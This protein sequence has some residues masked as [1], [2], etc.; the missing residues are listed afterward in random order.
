[1]TH[2]HVFDMDGTL[3]RG[4]ASVE[5][6]RHLG[7]FE[8]ASA[9]EDGW[10][11]GEI[12]ERGFWERM[13]P[14]WDGVSES[15]V[16]DAFAGASW[17]A[18]VREVLADVAAR[19]E[20]AIVISQSPHFFV[21]RLEGWGAHRAYGSRVGPDVPAGT[22]RTLTGR[23]KVEITREVLDGLGLTSDA[24]VAYGDSGSDTELFALLAHTVAVNATAALRERASA[25]YDGDDLR[26]A[27]A[28]GRALLERH[29][30]SGREPRP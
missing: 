15:E 16:D 6:S 24:C 9:I 12:D 10:L 23:D 11:A 18:G 14:L 2:L 29:A 3:L 17:I 19:G 7:T 1:M 27:Y 21:R 30:V 28:M 4:A 5:L 26:E 20:R 22:W 8:Q 25:V 13:V